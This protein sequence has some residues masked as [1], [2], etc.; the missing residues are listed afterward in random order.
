MKIDETIKNL[1]L[2]AD[3]WQD[4]F[5]DKEL[6]QIAKWLR[7]LKKLRKQVKHCKS[8]RKNNEH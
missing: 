2:S 8:E 5:T 1:E 6:R 4:A 3:T 7:E